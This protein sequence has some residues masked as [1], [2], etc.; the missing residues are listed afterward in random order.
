VAGVIDA[1]GEGVNGWSRGQRVGVG[2][3]RMTWRKILLTKVRQPV[4]ILV[5]TND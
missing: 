1:I 2:D 5:K 4:M 3:A